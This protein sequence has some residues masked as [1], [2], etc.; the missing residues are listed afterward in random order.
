MTNRFTERLPAPPGRAVASL[1][2][3]AC[4]V[5]FCSAVGLQAGQSIERRVYVSVVDE[6]GAP[7][8]DLSAPD[9]VV[10]EDGVVREV[11][12]ASR[13]TDPMQI[14]VLVDDTQAATRMILDERLALQ[15]FVKALHQ[16]NE[17]ALLTFGERPGILVD[18]TA[19]LPVLLAGVDKVFTRPGSGS[20][21]LQA[22]V[23]TT[24][25]LQKREAARPVIVVVTTEGEEF[26]NDYY[27]TVVETLQK[28]RAQ[29]H[30]IVRTTGEPNP[31]NEGNRNRTFVLAEGTQS[32]GGR[33]EFVLSDSALTMK[34]EEL[35]SEL[36]QQYLLVYA[37]PQTLI[38]PKRLEVSVRRPGLTVRAGTRADLP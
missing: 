21:L 22:I 38:P 14:A 34:L 11:L 2:A 27:V 25:G 1:A 10:R 28:S 13:A 32:T 24:R 9:F 7:V 33:R 31:A 30:A 37:R 8:A 4:A 26:S 6:K 29:F 16:G 3:A 20:Y 36:K 5:L 19:S 17:M 12:R 18:Y 35:A 23:E 15:A